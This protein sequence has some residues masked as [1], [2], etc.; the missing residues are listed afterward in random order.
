MPLAVKNKGYSHWN[1]NN[2]NS[3]FHSGSDIPRFFSS[4]KNAQ[5]CIIQWFSSPNL[6]YKY[7]IYDGD[8]SR[9]ETT[10]DNRKKEDLEILMVKIELPK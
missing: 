2:K 3:K 5:S 4:Y 10:K 1:P 9:F 8:D 6:T 7:S